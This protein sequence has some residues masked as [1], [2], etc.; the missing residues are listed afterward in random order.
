MK[1][2]PPVVDLTDA[3]ILRIGLMQMS[4]IRVNPIAAL[5]KALQEA[6]PGQQLESNEWRE[7]G[8]HWQ[9]GE[10]DIAAIADD[11]YNNGRWD[12]IRVIN[13]Q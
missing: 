2:E 1:P 13:R 9:K 7:A 8:Y 11:D 12:K 4:V 10:V 6:H 5:Y 3:D